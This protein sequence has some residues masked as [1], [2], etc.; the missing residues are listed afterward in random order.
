[1]KVCSDSCCSGIWLTAADGDAIVATRYDRITGFCH[2]TEIAV[3]EFETQVSTLARFK[4][5]SLE[6]A[7]SDA[8]CAND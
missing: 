7:Q 8:R 4:M 5:D 2:H 1:M 3:L 6:T